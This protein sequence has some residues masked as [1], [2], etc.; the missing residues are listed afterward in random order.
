MRHIWTSSLGAI[1]I[2]TTAPAS[3]Q[4]AAGVEAMRAEIATL[5]AQVQAM[6]ARMNA[7]AAPAQSASVGSVPDAV[8]PAGTPPLMDTAAAP[9]APAE[10]RTEIVWKGAPQIINK[11]GWS[12]KPRGRLQYDTAYVSSPRGIDDTGLGFSNE[13]RRG[14]LGVEGTF[15]G[16][17]LYK[18]EIDFADNRVELTDAFLGYAD[19]GFNLVIGQHNPFQSLDELTSSRF[20]TFIERAAFTDAFNFERRVGVSAGYTTGDLLVNLGVF[21]DNITDLA[22]DANNSRSVEGRAVYMPKLGDTQLHLA[23]SFHLRDLGD[24]PGARYRQRPLVHATDVRFI[25]TPALPVTDETS[26]GLEAA[27]IHGPLHVA[28]EAHWLNPTLEA[29]GDPTFFGGYAEVGWFITGERR[30]YRGGQWERT[31]P[32]RPVGEG[33]IGAFQLN[34][35]YDHLDLND[36]GILGGRQQGYLA[37]LIWTPI[38]YVR[39]G[40]NYGHL[41][42]DDAALP[43]LDGRDYSVDVLGMRAEV[44]F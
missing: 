19:K 42:Y 17:F 16:G 2:A 25:G 6:E 37:S 29:A 26:Y 32:L 22:D 24:V 35:R 40:V 20:S 15:P 39:F 31:P 23:G 18:F 36:A 1:A 10:P 27:A 44:D 30:G 8:A 11:A 4:D 3:A 28:A 14:R 33:G 41:I 38:A 5:K 13:L 34:A 21:T 9:A 12:F 43:S 7:M